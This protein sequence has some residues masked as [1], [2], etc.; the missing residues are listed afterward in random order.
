MTC[1]CGCEQ[2]ELFRPSLAADDATGQAAFK[3]L[4]WLPTG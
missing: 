1:W 4:E 2:E 3:A